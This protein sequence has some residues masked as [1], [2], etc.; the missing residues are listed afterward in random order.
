MMTRYIAATS[1]RLAIQHV[2]EDGHPTPLDALRDTYEGERVYQVVVTQVATAPRAT[3]LPD[4]QQCREQLKG[5][6]Q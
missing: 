6:R 1:E 4:W 3:E 5:E 2:L